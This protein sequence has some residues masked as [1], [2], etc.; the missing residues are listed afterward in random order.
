MWFIDLDTGE[1]LTLLD[2]KREWEQEIRF[3]EDHQD[4]TF[5]VY[6]YDVLMAT[7]SDRND[8]EIRGMTPREI[9]KIISN[10]RKSFGWDK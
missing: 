2:L 6:L 5:F 8:L 1:L 4:E 9:G 10:L 7:I 3:E